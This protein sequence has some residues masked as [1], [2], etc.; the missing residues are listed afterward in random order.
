MNKMTTLLSIVFITLFG[1]GETTNSEI[2]K[3]VEKSRTN[4]FQM[5]NLSDTEARQL[6]ETFN[7]FLAYQSDAKYSESMEYYPPELFTSEEQK[8]ASTDQMVQF[9]ERG[10]IQ[11]FQSAKLE[12]A[13]PWMDSEGKDITFVSFFVEHTITLENEL[14]D[15]A[16]AF[17]TNVRDKYGK[18]N[19]SFDANTNTY[20][21]AGPVK[22]FIVRL[23]DSDRMYIVN[24]EYIMMPS[25]TPIII[26][27]VI[28]EMKKFENE[29]RKRL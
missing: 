10:M 2:A 21:I 3:P 26:I 18:N 24:E 27:E 17:E 22:L 6:T 7:E 20:H 5:I 1:C 9:R 8:Q 13:A 29:A 14:K 11:R 16:K 4:G 15:K 25:V 23:P 12:W 19:Y 28:Q